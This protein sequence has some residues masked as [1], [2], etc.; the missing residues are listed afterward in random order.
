MNNIQQ[1]FDNFPGHAAFIE[2]QG[3]K[4]SNVT[5]LSVT[6]EALPRQHN[7]LSND[8]EE[9]AYIRSQRQEYYHTGRVFVTMNFGPNFVF[10]QTF[11]KEDLE[12]WRKEGT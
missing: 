5:G 9:I 4:I 8:P 10:K 12:H 1:W 7:Y 2:S 3:L 6:F 11:R